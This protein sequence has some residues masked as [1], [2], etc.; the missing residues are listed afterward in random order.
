MSSHQIREIAIVG[1]KSTGKT[2][3][4]TR[5][6]NSKFNSNEKLTI[7]IDYYNYTIDKNKNLFLWDIAGG[8]NYLQIAYPILKRVDTILY[9][10]NLN[11]DSLD[12]YLEWE[13][14]LLN[15]I[16]PKYMVVILSKFDL[17]KSK[18]KRDLSFIQ[19][20]CLALNIN[21]FMISVKN[22]DNILYDLFISR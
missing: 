18:Y 10:H 4:I 11:S 21:L 17:F 15:I 2:S 8:Y 13:S 16:R 9:I 22:G 5:L 1:E 7:G 3:I 20:R 19:S 6:F 12:V 14:Y